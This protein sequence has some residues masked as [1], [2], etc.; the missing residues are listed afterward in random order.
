MKRKRGQTA[1]ATETQSIQLITETDMEKVNNRQA[2]ITPV[3]EIR[4]KTT[5]EDTG[6]TGQRK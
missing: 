5:Y 4:K 6:D 1:T 2:Q 3:K